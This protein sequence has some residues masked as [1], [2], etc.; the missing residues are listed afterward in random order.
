MILQGST[1]S[2]FV[3][4]AQLALR[5]KGL[6]YQLQPLNPLQSADI[7][8]HR[9]PI[10]KVPILIDQRHE[11]VSGRV[12]THYL[13]DAYPVPPL[14]PGNALI[15]A[16]IRWLEDVAYSRLA[17]LMTGILFY[18]N[19]YQA[20]IQQKT[21]DFDAITHCLQYTLPKALD[22][23]AS[24]L[25]PNGFVCEHLSMAEISLWSVYRGG[26]MA[27]LRLDHRPQWHHY[28]HA[29]EQHPLIQTLMDEENHELNAFYAEPFE[30]Q[31]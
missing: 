5:Y 22:E 18:Q 13:D 1:F 25:P 26:W 31:P 10:G 7:M 27:G 14:Y 30:Q 28:L 16:H 11:I 2:P 9:H 24:Q 23:F 17:S 20:K 4:M 15:R 12:I 6:N 8:G 19:V 29:I 21:V 3:R